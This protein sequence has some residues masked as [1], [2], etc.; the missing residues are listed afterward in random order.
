VTNDYKSASNWV[1]TEVL[2]VVNEEKIAISAFPVS[3]ENLGK[4]IELINNNTISGKIAKDVFPEM[5]RSNKD[6]E[7]IVKEKNLVQITDTSAIES[8]V[9]KVLS[10][11]QKQVEE[12]LSGKEKVLGFLVGQIMRET[13]G[14]A[15]PQIVNEILRNKLNTRK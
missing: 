15:N 6:P 7:T 10:A 13:K 1:M 14:K 2:K 11:N 12:F 8:I 3:P 9:E 4:L 5:L